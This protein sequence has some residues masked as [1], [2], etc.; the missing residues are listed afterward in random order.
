MDTYVGYAIVSSIVLVMVW[1]AISH[2]NQGRRKTESLLGTLKM[3]DI[4]IEDTLPPS[5]TSQH[6]SLVGPRIEY[7]PDMTPFPTDSKA[8]HSDPRIRMKQEITELQGTNIERYSVLERSTEKMAECKGIIE[9]I[10]GLSEEYNIDV[11]QELIEAPLEGATLV[12]L[13]LRQ[14]ALLELSLIHI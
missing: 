8:P 13:E 11:N 3:E 7:S 1:Q 12:E 9:L 10:R 14:A 5:R 6:Q 2:L 4:E